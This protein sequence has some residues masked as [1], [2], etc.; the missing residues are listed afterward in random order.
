MKVIPIHKKDPL[1]KAF[2]SASPSV[3][4]GVA[5]ALPLQCP[6]EDASS[7]RYGEHTLTFDISSS[8]TTHWDITL[9]K[10]RNTEGSEVTVFQV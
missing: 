10:M 4:I 1:T 9:L 6:H 5:D 3:R 7:V 2:C 8:L